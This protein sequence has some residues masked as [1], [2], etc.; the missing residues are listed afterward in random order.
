MS[1]LLWKAAMIL[2]LWGGGYALLA[3]LS[4]GA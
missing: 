2:A 3:I 4:G 1:E